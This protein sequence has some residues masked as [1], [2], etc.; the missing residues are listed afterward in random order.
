DALLDTLDRSKIS[1][2]ILL[3]ETL[4][5]SIK[6]VGDIQNSPLQDVTDTTYSQKLKS[7]LEENTQKIEETIRNLNEVAN[8][9]IGSEVTQADINMI[10]RDIESKKELVAKSEQIKSEL[11]KRWKDSFLEYNA[12]IALDEIEKAKLKWFLSKKFAENGITKGLKEHSKASVD[13]NTLENDLK[14]QQMYKADLEAIKIAPDYRSFETAYEEYKVSKANYAELLKIREPEETETLISQ[15]DTY[16]NILNAR[17]S[18]KEWTGFNAAA[19]ELEDEGFTSL[20]K[21]VRE[22]RI[23]AD[24]VP[25][26]LKRQIAMSLSI[27]T[28]DNDQV[29]SS[30]SGVMFDEKIRQ[31][32]KLDKEVMELTRKEIYCRLAENVPQFTIE[33]AQSSEIGILQRAIKS[34]GRGVSI[35]K[36][37]KD[38]QNL[39]PRLCPC[40]LM[41]PLSAAQYLDPSLELF[42]MVVFDEASQIPTCKAV[43]ALARGKTAV[44]VGDPKQMPPTSFFMAEQT[45]EEHLDEEDLESILDDCLALSM[46]ETHLLWHYRSRHESLI[47]FSNKKFYDNRLYTFPSVNDRESK[48]TFVSVDGIFD[49]G[50]NRTNK[51]EAEAVIEE[52]KKRCHNEDLNKRSVGVVTFNIN[53]QNLIDDLLQ[54]ACKNDPELEKWAY[55]SEEPMFIKNLE[56]VQGDERDVILFSV[57]YG[58]DEDGNV[59]MNFGPLNRDGGWRR[60]NVAVSRA[61]YEMKVFSTLQPEMINLSRSSAEG[62][63]ALKAFLE[64][65][66]GKEIP[67]TENTLFAAEGTRSA[68]ADEISGRLNEK[69]YETTRLVGRSE[70]KIDIGVV[71]PENPGQYKLGI[72]LDGIPYRDSRTARDREI[73]QISVL[74]G[75]GWTLHRVWSMDWW[76]DP[77]KE[78]NK[79]IDI[80]TKEPDPEPDPEPEQPVPEEETAE[81]KTGENNAEGADPAPS[82]SEYEQYKTAELPIYD[83]GGGKPS[84]NRALIGQLVSK[85]VEAEGPV[86]RT[87]VVKRIAEATGLQK[88]T[89]ALNEQVGICKDQL[90]L[91]VTKEGDKE[92]FWPENTDP[93]KYDIFRVTTNK[94]REITDIPREEAAN[95]VVQVIGE[96]ISLSHQDL[97]KE[98]SKALGFMRL[99]TKVT[100]AMENAIAYASSAGLI[101]KGPNDNWIL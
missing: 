16:E 101:H 98:A 42:D 99:G 80:L 54:E 6:L 9:I 43:G 79:I 77:D 37:I 34:N 26:V 75:L 18:L 92:F 82:V 68:I 84:D 55:D 39:L 63:A 51:A 93:L 56:N 70:Y 52:L 86:S 81:D 22:G 78:I 15:I 48:V 53:Q 17:G 71:D 87:I 3:S 72:L 4:V 10:S 20:I 50:K 19:K 32:T 25:G 61:R 45:D 40:M 27:R 30:F 89:K 49:R 91:K 24:D 41:S 44:I 65:A 21:A 46:P 95:A 66:Q 11:S 5:T 96:Q 62:V 64:Y 88:N 69:G 13:M 73:S 83:L 33:G 2:A 23:S 31:F 94:E 35:R 12:Q 1:N 47:S 8:P 29:L 14:L 28:I 74:Q 100:E 59:Y 76:D 7:V 67:V 36:L 57:G 38:I 97:I 60:L 90:K 58:P 85:V